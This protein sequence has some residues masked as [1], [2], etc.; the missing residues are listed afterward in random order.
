MLEVIA[1]IPEYQFMIAGVS[2]L[3]A[4]VYKNIYPDNVNLHIDKTY[5]ILSVAKAAIVTSGT[6]TL[7]TALWN[8]PQ[9]VG[10]K[11]SRLTYAIGLRLVRITYF[12]LVNLIA[13]EKVVTELLQDACN[14]E[15]LSHEIRLLTEDEGR[16]TRVFEGYRKVKNILGNETASDKTARLMIAYLKESTQLS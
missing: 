2:S 11:T 9:V 7:E 1:R 14:V 13:D 15:T 12:S 10:Y 16:R 4:E 6:A 5:E 3:P 8:V